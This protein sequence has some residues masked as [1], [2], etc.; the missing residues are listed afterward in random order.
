[1]MGVTFMILHVVLSGWFPIDLIL[2]K[3]KGL[4]YVNDCIC[5]HMIWKVMSFVVPNLYLIKRVALLF[6]VA[7]AVR[8]RYYF[9]WLMSE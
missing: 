6:V 5:I 7:F 1:M 8:I 3:C 4:P 9:I 2:G